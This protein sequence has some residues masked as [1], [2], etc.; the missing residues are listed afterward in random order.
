MLTFLAG[1]Q[2]ASMVNLFSRYDQIELH[3]QSRNLIAFQI[4]IGLLRMTM[5]PQGATNSVAQFVHVGIVA[6]TVHCFSDSEESYGSMD[7]RQLSI[8]TEGLEP[9]V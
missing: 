4:L 6:G 1:F 3:V 2:T 7:S 5:L 8:R 9:S